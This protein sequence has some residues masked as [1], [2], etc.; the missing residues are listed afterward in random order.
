MKTVQPDEYKAI[1]K[2]QIAAGIEDAIEAI[3]E[4]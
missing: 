1:A 4:A 2:E 3:H